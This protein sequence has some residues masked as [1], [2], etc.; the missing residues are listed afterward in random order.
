MQGKEVVEW[1]N[2][3]GIL[4]EVAAGDAV[5]IDYM[6]GVM[7][8]VRIKYLRGETSLVHLASHR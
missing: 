1:D 2:D 6:N 5:F 8:Q 3:Y 4:E 7:P